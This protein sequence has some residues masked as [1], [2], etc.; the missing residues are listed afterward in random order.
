MQARGRWAAARSD[1]GAK[2]RQL[3][4]PGIDVA[5][6]RS[7]MAGGDPWFAARR[8]GQIGAK[9]G[10]L[11]LDAAEP[12]SQPG[13]VA[14]RRRVLQQGTGQPYAR[15]Q[16]VH[17]AQTFQPLRALGH[18]RSTGQLCLPAIACACVD[19]GRIHDL[20]L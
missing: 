6:Q 16:L 8:G 14:G 15:R 19:S 1:E 3:P 18:A 5:F 4:C 13:G 17:V 11:V 12:G 2:R 10:E 7:D 9:P 20:G